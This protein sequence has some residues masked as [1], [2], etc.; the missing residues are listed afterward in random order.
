MNIDRLKIVQKAF[1]K[2][3]Y[4]D[5]NEDLQFDIAVYYNNKRIVSIPQLSQMLGV[6]A[7][8]FNN[9]QS[10]GQIVPIT[11]ISDE[12]NTYVYLEQ[13]IASVLKDKKP[14]SVY[15]ALIN[16]DILA[17]VVDR[18]QRD[19]NNDKKETLSKSEMEELYSK[20]IEELTA[21]E[22][23]EKI[24]LLRVKL[25]QETGVL[26]PADDVD[27]AMAELA[28][29]FKTLYKGDLR[30]LPTLLENVCDKDEIKQILYT[31][32][33]RRFADLKKLIALKFEKDGFWET[34]NAVLETLKK[35]INPTKIIELL[36][37]ESKGKK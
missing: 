8:A 31:H 16:N 22:K 20:D 10:Y 1:D 11:A 4:T 29:T 35:G 21:I 3:N 19:T 7:R 14:V 30:T 2:S 15:K 5:I 25:K 9:M 18:V 34:M 32:Y 26:V 6:T 24:A 13:L 23:S 33:E 17:E 12:N 36:K 28:V 27:K 37:K